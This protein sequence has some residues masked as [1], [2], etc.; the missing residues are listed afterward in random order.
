MLGV[1]AALTM[2]DFSLLK[3]LKLKSASFKTW[4][5][6]LYAYPLLSVMLGVMSTWVPFSSS[7]KVFSVFLIANTVLLAAGIIHYLE[8]L[9][10]AEEVSQ[11]ATPSG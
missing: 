9:R 8:L 10:G 5:L 6:T 4:C 11:E 3:L 2:P 7:V 1:S